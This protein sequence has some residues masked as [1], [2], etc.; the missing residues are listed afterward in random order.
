MT[1]RQVRHTAM[2]AFLA[3]IT[4]AARESAAH[5]LEFSVETTADRRV[6][7]GGFYE[8]GVAMKDARVTVANRAGRTVFEGKTDAQGFA[9]FQPPGPDLYTFTLD[10]GAGHQIRDRFLLASFQLD[11]TVRDLFA[12]GGVPR[13]WVEKVKTL[14]RWL[15][16]LFGLSLILNVFAGLGWWRTA[17]ELR[18]RKGNTA[19]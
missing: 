5:G 13:T 15:T 19:S 9:F 18:R 4:L 14:P 3:V 2:L 12:A 10:D 17:R 11:G 8:G 1:G 7:I 16:A 6:R